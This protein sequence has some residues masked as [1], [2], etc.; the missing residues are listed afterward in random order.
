MTQDPLCRLVAVQ[1]YS[2][3]RVSRGFQM[4]IE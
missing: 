3:A 2:E 1:V 4:L